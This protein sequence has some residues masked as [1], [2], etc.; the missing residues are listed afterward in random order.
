[1]KG[2]S[3]VAAFQ[4]RW[5]AL[6]TVSVSRKTGTQPSS[7]SA[8]AGV[9]GERGSLTL[10][11]NQSHAVAAGG[12]GLVGRT[13]DIKVFRELGKKAPSSACCSDGSTTTPKTEKRPRGN[14]SQQPKSRRR[15]CTQQRPELKLEERAVERCS[16]EKRFCGVLL[17]KEGL[18]PAAALLPKEGLPGQPTQQ[19]S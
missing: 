16:D 8:A 6:L 19:M 13:S 15:V 4:R 10:W 7:T 2:T 5:P 3:A 17:L 9:G 1:M 11:R 18:R 14:V 12:G